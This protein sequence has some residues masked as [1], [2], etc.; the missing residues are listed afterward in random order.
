MLVSSIVIYACVVYIK[1]M[2]VPTILSRDRHGVNHNP[3]PA[4]VG[5]HDDV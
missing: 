4:S 3:K 1:R 2:Y 5:F